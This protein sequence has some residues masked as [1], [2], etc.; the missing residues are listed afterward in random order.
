M[1]PFHLSLPL[2]QAPI[3]SNFGDFVQQPLKPPSSLIVLTLLSTSSLTRLVGFIFIP[4]LLYLLLDF[5]RGNVEDGSNCVG[6][7]TTTG[8][9]RYAN[10]EGD[11][12]I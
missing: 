12:R 2:S 1:L 3:E 7:S 11:Y 6:N 9:A 10:P 5:M 4:I 8:N